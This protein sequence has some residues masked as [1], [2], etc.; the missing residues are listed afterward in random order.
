MILI[1]VMIVS[2]LNLTAQLLIQFYAPELA[3]SQQAWSMMC[4]SLFVCLAALSLMAMKDRDNYRNA[5]FLPFLA[6][7]FVLWLH[8]GVKLA[9]IIYLS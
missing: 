8:A 7:T 9:K 4:V 2:V 1:S 5:W 6:V 3:D